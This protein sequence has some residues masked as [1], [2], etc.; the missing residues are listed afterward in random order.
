M[1]RCCTG[2]AVLGFLFLAI[3]YFPGL[4]AQEKGNRMLRHV[5]MF[6]FKEATSKEDIQ[7]VV[8]AFRR[9]KTSIPEIA[10]FEFG[11]DNSPE[12]LAN[13]FTHCFLISFKSEKD[14]EVYLPHPK[15]KEF[16]EVL[17]PHLD[18]VQVI[19]YWAT[20]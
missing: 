17:K 9:L 14:R 18:K 8:D 1:V 12:G 4:S 20:E 16:V 6:K 3:S 11:T 2:A 7:K 13:G 10:A 5:V 19:D 15:H